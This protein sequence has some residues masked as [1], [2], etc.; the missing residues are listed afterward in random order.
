MFKKELFF[1]KLLVGSVAGSDTLYFLAVC[2]GPYSHVTSQS[3][4]L[5]HLL[6]VCG[7]AM[8]Y[9]T[10][11]F[12]VSGETV[13]SLYFCLAHVRHDAFSSLERSP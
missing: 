6:V 5:Q 13:R 12:K 9:S 10:Y 8:G 2:S 1:D 11:Q 7:N 3:F 4:S